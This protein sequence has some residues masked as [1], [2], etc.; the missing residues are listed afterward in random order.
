MNYIDEM[1]LDATRYESGSKDN[2]PENALFLSASMLGN[3]PLQ[4]YLRTIHGNTEQ[5]K[6]ED[7][8]LG[9]VLHLGMEQVVLKSKD[10]ILDKALSVE[11]EKPMHIQITDD[12]FFTGTADLVIEMHDIVYIHDYKFVKA[13]SLTKYNEQL[14]DIDT[15][16]HQYVYQ[17][18]GL[19]YL[20]QQ[21][22]PEKDIF[23]QLDFFIRD[24][25]K[26]KGESVHESPVIP[27]IGNIEDIIK[28]KISDLDKA[29]KNL[30][31]PPI[32]SDLWARKIKG[33]F[34]PDVR[35]QF[36]CDQKNNCPYY[37]NKGKHGFDKNVHV[38]LNW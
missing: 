1:I 36:Y 7:N 28:T 20:A 17:M 16:Y 31:V 5:E 29:I 19:R 27:Y 26:L 12:W 33:K 32:C 6:V 34:I 24:A 4:N 25:N 8:T 11:T 38:A 23:T 37:K 3:E 30:E 14:K 18:N 15:D 10:K 13:Y 22:Y 9:S 35:C 21:Y 2:I